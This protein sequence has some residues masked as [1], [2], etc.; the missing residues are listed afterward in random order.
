MT[1][2][3]ATPRPSGPA[4]APAAVPGGRERLRPAVLFPAAAL[5]LLAVCTAALCLGKP[6]LAPAAITAAIADPG[7]L[8]AVILWEIRLPRMLLGLL[9]GAALGCA[10][11]LLQEALRNPLAVPE[12]LGVSSGSAAVV[13]ATTVFA[14]PVAGALVP[15][16]ALAGGVAGGALCLVV[17]RRAG[18][19]ASVLLTGAAVST[20]LTGAV[21]AITSMAD[22]FQLGLVFRYLMG[23][24]VGS[25]WAELRM[26][27]PWLV[28][29][30]PLLLLCLPLLGVLGLGDDAASALGLSPGR[31]RL[32]C[33]AVAAVLVAVVV[34]ACGPISWVGFLAPMLARQTYPRAEPRVRL[35]WSGLLGGLVT[36]AADLAARTMFHPIELPLGAFTGSIGVIGGL[37]LLRARAA[38]VDGRART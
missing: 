7:S 17:A 26:V 5:L 16:L 6:V 38:A 10:G 11:L 15:A 20:A 23:S 32:A 29:A 33:L 27:A 8:D 28:L 35:L 1:S 9:A 34:A 25:G 14:L 3:A 19:A 13:A 22:Q 12:L 24:L 2:P 21:Y 4:P 18:D 37:L 36:V 31:A 30:V